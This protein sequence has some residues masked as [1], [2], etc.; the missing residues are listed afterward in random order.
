MIAFVRQVLDTRKALISGMLAFLA[1]MAVFVYFFD[2][3][4][5]IAMSGLPYTSFQ[6]GLSSIIAVLFGLNIAVLV[7]EFQAQRALGKSASASFAGVALGALATGCPVCGTGLLT[8]V[9]GM[10]GIAGGLALLPFKGLELKLLSIA[11]LGGVLVVK[12]QKPKTCA[13]K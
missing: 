1:A 8:A 5:S 6:L 7:N 4:T 12:A 9:L 10:F 13:I 11:L 2:V 3:P